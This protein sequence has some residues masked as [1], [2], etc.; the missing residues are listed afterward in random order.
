MIRTALRPAWLALLALLVVIV[1]SFYQLGMWQIGVSS[2][3]A[4]REHA[5]A[6]A[7]RPTEPLGE[8]TAPHQPFPDDGAGLSVFAE[9]EYAASEQFLVP[10]RL[11]QDEP[12]YWVVTPLR[13]AASGEAA[14]LPVVRGF[15]TDP[16]QAD[17]PPAD[18]VKVT[19][20]LAPSESP[21]ESAGLGALPQG[22]RATIDTADLV[23]DW[24]GP[25]YNAFVF[26]V[27]EQPAV[28]ATSVVRIPPPVFGDSGIVWR[29]FGYGLQWFT[30]AAFAVYMY[31][32]FLRQATPG[33]REE[34]GAGE[35]PHT[36]SPHAPIQEETPCPPVPS[37]RS[38]V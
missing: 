32:R 6:Q 5:A 36:P 20:T 37:S 22:Q 19:G 33:R 24:D 25:V 18:P 28:T 17:L 23:N 21:G 31:I 12:G 26:L 29:N 34:Q 3:D 11:L 35:P 4:A 10:G 9:G 8:V 7:A 38:S 15:V 16:V 13:T 1:W 27:D 2:N 14:L 30:F